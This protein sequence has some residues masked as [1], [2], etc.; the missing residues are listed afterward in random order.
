MTNV[1]CPFCFS[2]IDSSHLAFQC[3]GRGMPKCKLEPDEKREHLAGSSIASYPT[4]TC[5][6]RKVDE[7]R[8]PSCGGASRR[9]ACPDCHMALPADFIGS[10]SPLIGIVGAR[11][12]GKSVWMTVL[13]RELRDS[14]AS[15]FGAY[16]GFA[17]DNPGGE[18]SM[19]AWLNGRERTMFEDKQLPAATAAGARA[20]RLPLVLRWQ[21]P[22]RG[23]LHKGSPDSTV[24]SFLDTAGED[25]QSLDGVLNLRYLG[26]VGGLIMMVDPFRISGAMAMANVPESQRQTGDG[27][28]TEV[29]ERMTEALRTEHRVKPK[30]KIPVP[31]AVVFTKLDAFFPQLDPGNPLRSPSSQVPYYDESMGREIHEQVLSLMERWGASSLETHLG[32]NYEQYRY[33][34]LSSLGAEPDYSSGIIDSSG[35]RPHRVED[36]FL[37]LLSVFGVVARQ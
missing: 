24:L 35:V 9:R 3:M 13:A 21:Q 31:T 33:F 19:S 4:F 36:P 32:L 34:A 20:H 8:C 5:D 11:S 16:V 29:V 26:A 28:P 2:I 22:S 6:D 1:A 7:A 10:N 37:W 12:S 15:R 25:Q 14:V 30:K 17:T 27:G 18:S 23:V